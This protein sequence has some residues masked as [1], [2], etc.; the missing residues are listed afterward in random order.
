MTPVKVLYLISKAID[1]HC[2]SII[3]H[4]QNIRAVLEQLDSSK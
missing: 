4:A 1:L 2:A 3:G